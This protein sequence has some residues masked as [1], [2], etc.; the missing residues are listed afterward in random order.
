[1][2]IDGPKCDQIRQLRWLW[3][4][5]FGDTEAFLN[6]FFSLAF[7]PDRC[8]CVTEDGRVTA[9]LYWFDCLCQ[10]EKLA[11]L[12]AVATAKD[13]RGRGLCRSLLEDTH[14]HLKN[15]GYAGTILVPA[16]DALRQMYGRMGYLPAAAVAEF[17]CPAGERPVALQTL[18]AEQ[19]SFRRQKMLPADAVNQEGPLIDLLAD[20]CGLF[21]GEDFLLAA[22]VEGGVLHTEEFLGSRAAAPGIVTALGAEKGV[23]RAPG[24]DKPFAMYRPLGK[25]CPK[26]GYFGIALG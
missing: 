16:D 19:Y 24:W 3:Q 18:T 26:P 25:G 21:G 14:A 13:C 8:R 9:A 1:M 12:Y 7:S 2:T 23:F 10:G 20:Q 22:W 6:S 17:T 4:E 5:A 15:K 11:Y